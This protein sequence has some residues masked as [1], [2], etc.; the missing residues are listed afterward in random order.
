LESSIE[1]LSALKLLNLRDN[2][3]E[4][5]LPLS[6]SAMSN[7][8][9]LHLDGNA[10]SGTLPQSAQFLFGCVEVTL[11]SNYFTGNIPSDLG[12]TRGGILEEGLKID[13]SIERIDWHSN[14][15]SGIIPSL[16]GSMPSLEHVDISRNLLVGDLSN[17]F[18]VSTLGTAI[19]FVVE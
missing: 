14:R 9:Y 1:R 13:F 15:I 8:D 7:L 17:I 3:L 11:A 16:F 2:T 5:T 12:S 19:S 6:I 10:F 18:M 4:G